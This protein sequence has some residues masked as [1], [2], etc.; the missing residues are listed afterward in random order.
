MTVAVPVS[1]ESAVAEARRR[2]V[3]A[4]TA[5]GVDEVQAGQVAIVATELATNLV[6]HGSGG[7]LL[8]GTGERAIE[9]LA[10]DRGPGMS[11][12]ARCLADG[13]SSAGTPGN[14]LGAVRRLSQQ[15][16][17]ASWPGK[18]TAVYARV[19]RAEAGP[20]PAIAG[21]VV[22]KPGEDACGDAWAWHEDAEGRTVF[23][24]DGLGHGTDAA[25]AANEAVRQFMRSRAEAPADIVQAVHLAL[26]HTRGGAVAVARIVWASATVVYAGLG[27][28][29][30]TVAGPGGQL[31]RMVSHNGTA[32][33]NARKIQAFEYPCGGGPLIMHTDGI[34]TGWTLG[35]YP[36]LAQAHPML[37]AGVLYRDHARGRDDATVVVTATSPP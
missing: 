36:G 10:L 20:A 23:V 24:V 6:K 27:N 12:I 5:L 29:A 4:A 33:H 34:G 18:G 21:V 8:V 35:P 7:R 9:L 25:V 30:G 22:A 32:G 28:I 26:R 13:Y 19:A 15:V 3:A 2:A 1:D 17:I 37:A 11:D 14:G 16:E 31:R